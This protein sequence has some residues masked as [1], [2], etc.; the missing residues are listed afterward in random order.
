MANVGYLPDG[1]T[2]AFFVRLQVFHVGTWRMVF[3]IEG[4]RKKG[5][6]EKER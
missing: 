3:E 6:I 5:L 2:K 1:F 4:E